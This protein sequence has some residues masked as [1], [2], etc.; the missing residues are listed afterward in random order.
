VVRAIGLIS[1]TSLDGVDVALLETDGERFAVF[2]RTGYR[3]FSEDEQALLRQAPT[4]GSAL[5]DRTARPGVLAEAD[6]FVSC[7]HAEA[8]EKLLADE[9]IDRAEIVI[10]GFHGQTLPHKPAAWLTVQIGDGRLLAA[11]LNLPVAY[12]FRAGR[13]RRW[14]RCSTGRAS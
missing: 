8:V 6:A 10:V 4:Q 11:R 13:A 7:A 2:G 1:G 5:S 9:Q 3:P 14:C 12:D